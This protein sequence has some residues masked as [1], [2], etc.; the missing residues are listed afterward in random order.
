M[1]KEKVDIDGEKGAK[2]SIVTKK[3]VTKMIQR[4]RLWSTNKLYII[5]V[6]CFCFSYYYVSYYWF[7]QKAGI[8]FTGYFY[9]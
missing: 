6:F 3:I 8:T 5:F 2:I 1:Q 4:L 7:D 9:F